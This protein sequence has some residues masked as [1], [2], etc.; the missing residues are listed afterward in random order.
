MQT[1]LWDC[2]NLHGMISRRNGAYVAGASDLIAS[3]RNARETKLRLMQ[4]AGL[5]EREWNAANTSYYRSGQFKRDLDTA[6]LQ[7]LT[8]RPE[9]HARITD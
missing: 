2:L 6:I 7:A 8:L 4:E 5:T 3:N 9:F 1:E